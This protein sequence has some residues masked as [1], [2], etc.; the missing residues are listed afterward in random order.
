MIRVYF[1]L[2]LFFNCFV[3]N[4]FRFLRWIFLLMFFFKIDRFCCF[5]IFDMFRFFLF[6]V[7]L[8]FIWKIFGDEDGFNVGINCLV[9]ER[10]F[11]IWVSLNVF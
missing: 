1:K 6:I 3:K 4:D 2:C 10:K 9:E 7:I 11:K 5:M 8:V